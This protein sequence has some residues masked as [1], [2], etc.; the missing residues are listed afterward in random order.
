MDREKYNDE[1]KERQTTGD[2]ERFEMDGGG[3]VT[4]RVSYLGHSVLAGRIEVFSIYG[5]RSHR[6]RIITAL[7]QESSPSARSLHPLL[8]STPLA[9][10]CSLPFHS[11]PGNPSVYRRFLFVLHLIYPSSFVSLFSFPSLLSC[12]SQPLLAFFL[13]LSP[14]PPLSYRSPSRKRQQEVSI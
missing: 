10:P 2:G 5:N 11:S 3:R 7:C 1:W 13:P 8:A 6:R 12:I 4:S 9:I 14:P